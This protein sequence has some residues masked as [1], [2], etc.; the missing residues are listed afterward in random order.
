MIIIL[1]RFSIPIISSCFP[2]CTLL[3]Y[4][5]R[6]IAFAIVSFTKVDLPLPLTPVTHVILFNG[7]STSIF[8]KLFS[9]ALII[10][11]LLLFPGLLVVGT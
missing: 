11:K 7:I 9:R 5:F 2:T 4:S 10:F 6:L 1:S 3:L 8:F